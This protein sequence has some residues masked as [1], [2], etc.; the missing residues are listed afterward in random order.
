MYVDLK[1]ALQLAMVLLCLAALVANAV[2]QRR[3]NR[4]WGKLASQDEL[5]WLRHRQA[6]EQ[7]VEDLDHMER[8]PISYD[9]SSD[10]PPIEPET[11]HDRDEEGRQER[12]VL[13]AEYLKQFGQ[14]NTRRKTQDRAAGLITLTD[15]HEAR[16]E[17]ESGIP[18]GS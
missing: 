17:E 18:E 7:R 3:I 1:I 2:I 16:L 8:N 9:Q 6:L 4:L 10:R 15:D 13:E 5:V 12:A 14:V 11:Y